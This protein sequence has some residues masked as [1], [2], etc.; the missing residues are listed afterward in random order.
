MLSAVLGFFAG[1]L[2][3]QFLIQAVYSFLVVL[4]VV[5][6]LLVARVRAQ[7]NLTHLLAVVPQTVVSAALAYG[8]SWLTGRNLDFSNW[9]LGTVCAALGFTF[10]ALYAAPQIGGKLLL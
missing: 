10:A 1:A 7:E 3:A 4:I 2:F 5:S 6:G 9:N 8:L